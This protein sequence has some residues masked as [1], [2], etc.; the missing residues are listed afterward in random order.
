MGK[1]ISKLLGGGNIFNCKGSFLKRTSVRIKGANN[2]VDIEP[3]LTRMK[4]C[5]IIIN[6]SCCHVRV[7]QDSNLNYTTIY[8]EDDN[9]S[10]V[11][12]QHVT[13]MGNT[14]L[15]AIE[16]KSIVIGDNCL[17]S[18]GIEFRTGDSH[19]ILDALSGRRINP[20]ADIEVGKHVWIGHDVKVLKGTTIS[21]N[22]IVAT[23]AI[24]TGKS[25]PA[26]TVIA[27]IPAE[28]VKDCVD[29]CSERIKIN[30]E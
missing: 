22:S 4:H 26:N 7:G 10:I 5:F 20:S 18:D 21:N 8:I 2:I 16:G 19:S 9:T 15:A 14:Q 1:I 30:D 17:F 27:G 11:I 25:Y 6:G 29:W 23:G 28:V 13:I 24:L 3:G 12:G